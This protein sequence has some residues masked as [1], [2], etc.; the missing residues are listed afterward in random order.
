MAVFSW[1]MAS[2][3]FGVICGTINERE[4]GVCL[5]SISDFGL[6]ARVQCNQNVQSFN[7]L[8]REMLVFS[9]C[10]IWPVGAIVCRLTNSYSR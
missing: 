3:V 1:C 7:S 2:D 4:M 5:P 8:M 6:L 9:D 10:S